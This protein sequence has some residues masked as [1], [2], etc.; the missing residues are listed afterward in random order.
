[1]ANRNLTVV[2]RSS[3]FKDYVSAKERL[4]ICGIQ[5]KSSNKKNRF[6]EKKNGFSNPLR[7]YDSKIAL[8]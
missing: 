8:V 7:F 4:Q 2:S 5:H 6:I 3:Q 1:M